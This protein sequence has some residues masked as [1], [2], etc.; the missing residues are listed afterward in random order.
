MAGRFFLELGLVPSHL[1]SQR[2]RGGMAD[3]PDLGSGSER[4]GGSS[5]LARTMLKCL[6]KPAKMPDFRLQSV[7][8][9]FWC[10]ALLCALL[11]LPSFANGGA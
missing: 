6:V 10:S 7:L 3:A 9:R 2:A 8:V 5:P 4:I 1:L 11:H